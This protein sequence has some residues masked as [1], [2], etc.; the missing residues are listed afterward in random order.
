MWIYVIGRLRLKSDHKCPTRLG[1]VLS[2]RDRSKCA[3]SGKP[4][5][6][7]CRSLE[8]RPAGRL[9]LFVYGFC[10]TKFILVRHHAI[11]L[12]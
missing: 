5:A 10:D 3:C 2:E 7:S 12:Y 9:V 11:L 6:D 1:S 8:K 4:R